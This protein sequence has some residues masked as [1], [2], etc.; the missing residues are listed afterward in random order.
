MYVR[1]NARAVR[2]LLLVSA[3]D[4]P[5]INLIRPLNPPGRRPHGVCST[6]LQLLCSPSTI[7]KMCSTN[8]CQI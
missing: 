1:F 7:V 2:M 5:S 3:Y 8:R 4:I 6:R